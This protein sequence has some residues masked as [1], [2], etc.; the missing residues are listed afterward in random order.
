MLKEKAAILQKHDSEHLFRGAP[1]IHRD[2][3]RGKKFFS[4]KT[5]DRITENFIM[6]AASFV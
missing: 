5:E 2:G 4:P 6:G 3:V 1:H